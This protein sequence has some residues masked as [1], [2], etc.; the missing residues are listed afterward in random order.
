MQ[1]LFV[2]F[3]EML[4]Q[5]SDDLLKKNMFDI[6]DQINNST[7]KMASATKFIDFFVHDILD[8]TILNKDETNFNKNITI[9]NV[10]EA[11]EEILETLDDK[12]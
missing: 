2:L 6:Y 5:I 4:S 1:S 10:K 3:I 7:K 11:V 12:V 8:Y 9:F